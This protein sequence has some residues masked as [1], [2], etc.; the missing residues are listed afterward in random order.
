MPSNAHP[1][2]APRPAANKPM[3]YWLL[4]LFRPIKV[5]MA[6][7]PTGW[8]AGFKLNPPPVA[9][10]VGILCNLDADHTQYYALR[11]RRGPGGCSTYVNVVKATVR[12]S[13]QHRQPCP[14]NRAGL[15]PPRH[16]VRAGTWYTI[17]RSVSAGLGARAYSQQ[18][19]C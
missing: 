14:L 9:D 8:Q 6:R 17:L 15:Q 1:P 5:E 3:H 16:E 13:Q 7:G 2:I 10:V 18:A 19:R 12:N 11:L 4:C